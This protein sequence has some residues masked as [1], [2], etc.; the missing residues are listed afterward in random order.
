MLHVDPSILVTAL[1]ATT[2]V[3]VCFA[4]TAL[5]A[6]RRSFLYLGGVLSSCVMGEREV[7]IAADPVVLVW[8]WLWFWFWS[9]LSVIM[10]PSCCL[11]NGCGSSRVPSHRPPISPRHL[12]LDESRQ[13]KPRPDHPWGGML[14]IRRSSTKLTFCHLISCWTAAVLGL[15]SSFGHKRCCSPLAI[16]SIPLCGGPDPLHRGLVPFPLSALQC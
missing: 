10:W 16:R 7:G 13:R 4:G 1:L 12:M 15:F 5:F 9:W 11:T 2:T 6:K 14:T 3:F 8:L